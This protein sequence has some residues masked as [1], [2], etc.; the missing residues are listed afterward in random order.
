MPYSFRDPGPRRHAET[1]A[2][3]RSPVEDSPDT[4][5]I[6][7]CAWELDRAVLVDDRRQEQDRCHALGIER[8]VLRMFE[9][10]CLAGWPTLAAGRTK[11]VSRLRRRVSSMQPRR[12]VETRPFT[13]SAWFASADRLTRPCACLPGLV[14]TG[15]GRECRWR[16]T[17]GRNA[18]VGPSGELL[19]SQRTERPWGTLCDPRRSIPPGRALK[20]GPEPRGKTEA[21]LTKPRRSDGTRPRKK[22]APSSGAGPRARWAPSAAH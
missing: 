8:D 10:A 17:R 13:D 21:A 15:A 4:L 20:A 1:P 9:N 22:P 12:M 18:L 11:A 16:V 6:R 5:Y 3:V 14:A 7:T 2:L 19:A